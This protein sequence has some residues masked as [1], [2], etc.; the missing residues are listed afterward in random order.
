MQYVGFRG[1]PG[2]LLYRSFYLGPSN[3]KI[4]EGNAPEKPIL[5]LQRCLL[6]SGL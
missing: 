4:S 3:T 1:L 2:R 5:L 6:F